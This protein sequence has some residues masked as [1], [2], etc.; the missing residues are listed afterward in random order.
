MSAA[1]DRQT[2]NIR[3]P[4]VLGVL[5]VV[6]LLCAF[7]AWA[8]VAHIAGAV[9]GNGTIEVQTTRTA[10]QHPIGGIVVEVLKQDGDHVD[11]GEV[12]LRLDDR[13]L[14]SNLVVTEGALFETLANIARLE[15][16]LE[17]RREMEL[18]PLLAGAL[19]GNAELQDLIARL[20]AQ[21][22]DQF[23]AIDTEQRLLDEQIV[24]NEAQ[25]AG[26]EAQLAARQ[27]EIAIIA[28]EL[29]NARQ[30]S[31][32]GLI[33]SFELNE[34]EKEDVDAQGEMGRLTAQIAELRGKIAETGLKRLSVRTDAAELI[35]VELSRLRPER[36][37]L[38]EARNGI[39]DSLEQLEIRAPVSGR[40][41]D[42]RVFG[43]QSVVVAASP[44]MM[45]VP[46][47]DPV[48]VRVRVA[49]TDID[50]V[51]VGQDASLK[52]KSFNGRSIPIILGTV[53][54][55]SADAF[56]DQKTQLP[57][58]EVV[59]GL[60]D[61][62]MVKLGNGDL[63]PGMPVEAFLATESRTPV[64]YI[65]RPILVYLDRAFRDS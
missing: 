4:L 29:A 49:S 15:A 7:G 25:I 28:T 19:P 34:L 11:A 47:D 35:S 31:A 55:I 44:L 10:V 61:Q 1:P 16:A 8:A 39:L 40:I 9:I 52:F 43:V 6:G 38:L 18:H 14:R 57:Y 27:D 22:D 37:R 50:Q 30:L 36:T 48:R 53:R 54:Q 64:S 32:N 46:E 23:T 33:R 24:Q 26:V 65:M 59:V 62:E 41:I 21:L 17:G 45:I 12:I 42:S 5:T 60:D 58:Y 13:Q 63:L 56:V 3:R 20:Q 51:F 2:W